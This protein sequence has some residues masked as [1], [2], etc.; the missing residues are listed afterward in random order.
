MV[1]F[2]VMLINIKYSISVRLSF[3]VFSFSF[4]LFTQSAVAHGW[5]ATT[6]DPNMRAE[7]I[8]GYFGIIHHIKP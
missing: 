2:Y 3:F 7:V 8:A 4:L 1:I 6:S 5:P